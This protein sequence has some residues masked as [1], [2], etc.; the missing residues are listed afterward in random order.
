ME[1]L[2]LLTVG[3]AHHAPYL[4]LS[5]GLLAGGLQGRRWILV[6]NSPDRA[7]RAVAQDCGFHWIEGAAAPEPDAG[8]PFHAI[9]SFHH[10]LGLSRGVDAASARYLL[11]LDP[12]FFLL[13]EGVVSTLL[14]RMRDEGLVALGVPWT[15]ELH[16]KW[17]GAPCM[18]CLLIDLEQIPKDALQFEPSSGPSMN[19]TV[20]RYARFA[21]LFRPLRPLLSPVHQVTTGRIGIGHSC[22]TG[23][24]LARWLLQHHADRIGLL[25]AAVEDRRRFRHPW[26]LRYG[27]GWNLERHLPERWSYLPPADHYRLIEGAD[28]A[29]LVRFGLDAF[30]L[31]DRIFAVHVRRS[32]AL[33]TDAA[34]EAAYVDRLSELLNRLA[35][36]Q[37]P[38]SEPEL[39]ASSGPL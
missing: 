18:H 34:A 26:H 22:D 23:W 33:F 13:G 36:A 30:C 37:D 1:E 6:D 7:L 12:D 24:Q 8:A 16:Y 3:L 2:A 17:R 29:D 19:K 32:R 21:R 27:W 5:H 11:I 25:P 20:D 35:A 39:L 4:R 28:I 31:D 15:P 38:T 10:A 14:A 9:G